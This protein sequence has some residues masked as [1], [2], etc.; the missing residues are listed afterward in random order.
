MPDLTISMINDQIKAQSSALSGSNRI[1]VFG[2]AHG[3]ALQSI[4]SDSIAIVSLNCIGQLPPSFI[5]YV[6]ARD[7]ADGIVL[8]GCRENSCNAR[9]G[10]AYSMDR[11]A[12][13]RDPH[14]R[15]RVPK[16]KIKVAWVGSSGTGQLRQVLETFAGELLAEA[17]KNTAPASANPAS[18][19]PKEGGYV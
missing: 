10:I 13:K 3:P 7:F 8:T 5:D 15:R 17:S 16:E 12:G 9:D 11:L 1:V 19:A 14:L 4:A 2:C 18:P 6:L